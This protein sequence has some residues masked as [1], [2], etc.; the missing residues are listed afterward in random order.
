VNHYKKTEEIFNQIAVK[1]KG[2]YDAEFTGKLKHSRYQRSIHKKV[3]KIL[4]GIGSGSVLEVGCGNG[5]YL[6]KQAKNNPEQIFRGV[7][8]SREQIKLASSNSKHLENISFGVRDALDLKGEGSGFNTILCINVLHHIIE[9]DQDKVLAE[10]ASLS[11]DNIILEIKNKSNIY[12]RSIKTNFGKHKANF[13]FRGKETDVYPTTVNI[14]T[15]VMKELN[16]KF[17][18]AYSLWLLKCLSPLILLHFKK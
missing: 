4:S 2:Y 14:V 11:P 10:I 3:E 6:I 17:S 1:N 12:Y 8:F 13:T 9:I 16:Y 18:R 5:D 15:S 7:D